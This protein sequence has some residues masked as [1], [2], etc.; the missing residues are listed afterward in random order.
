MQPKRLIVLANSIKKSARCVAG[1]DVGTGR[2]P[3]PAGWIRPVSGEAEGQLEPRHMRMN[4]G[5][6]LVPLDVVDVPLIRCAN[7][8]VHPEDWVLDSRTT[9]KR[10]GRLETQSLQALEQ[11]PSHLWRESETHTDRVTAHFLLRCTDHQSLYLIRPKDFRVELSCE[12]NPYMETYQKR[13]RA[14]FRYNSQEY[15]FGLTD[16]LFTETYRTAYPAPGG[17]AALFRPPFQDNCLF[18]VSLTPLFNGYHF[19]VVA[20]VLELQ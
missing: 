13:V 18:C 20:T 7:D 16:P 5:G 17:P 10:V 19:K 12:H 15:R 6:P 14:R 1:I 2:T 3:V 8:P 11:H 4:D 9:W